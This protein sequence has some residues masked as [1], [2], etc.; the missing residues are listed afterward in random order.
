ML[1]RE[2]LSRGYTQWAEVHWSIAGTTEQARKW[3][4]DK[5]L[6]GDFYPI[7]FNEPDDDK[8][9]E[10]RIGFWLPIKDTAHK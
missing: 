8:P 3:F 6:S 4:A 10:G 5:G 7:Y 9:R 2:F 1:V